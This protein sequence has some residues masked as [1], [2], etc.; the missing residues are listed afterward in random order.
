MESG[1]G[2]VRMGEALGA[3]RNGRGARAI[4]LPQTLLRE[5]G[6]KNRAVESMLFRSV[7]SMLPG[8]REA[9]AT[10]EQKWGLRTQPRQA[11]RVGISQWGRRCHRGV[12][13]GDWEEAGTVKSLSH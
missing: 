8:P 6:R 2:S 13:S 4:R 11:V 3:C 7:F 12:E 1:S 9:R 10:G 5:A